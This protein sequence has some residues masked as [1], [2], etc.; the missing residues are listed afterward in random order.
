M[1]VIHEMATDKWVRR[2]V[3]PTRVHCLFKNSFG[4]SAL[5][6]ECIMA[7]SVIVPYAG[8]IVILNSLFISPFL[9]RGSTFLLLYFFFSLSYSSEAEIGIRNRINWDIKWI[10]NKDW[11]WVNRKKNWTGQLK[12]FTINKKDRQSAGSFPCNLTGSHSCA[13]GDHA[14][15]NANVLRII[16]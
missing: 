4:R 14:I 13:E 15:K 5:D 3:L 11:D 1:S 7:N 10:S 12:S 9:T 6:L 2:T 8:G 16:L